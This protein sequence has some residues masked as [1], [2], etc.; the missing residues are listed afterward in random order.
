M[1]ITVQGADAVVADLTGFHSKVNK[2]AV[3]AL[4][5]AL[6]AGRTAMARDIASDTGIGV[7]DVT[8]ALSERKATIDRA[9]AAF[10]A[11]IRRIPLIYFKARQTAT[12]VTAKL[13]GGAGRYPSAFIARMRSGHEGVFRRKYVGSIG[14]RMTKRLPIVELFG[15]SLGHVFAKHRPAA[16]ARTQ[17][18]FHAAFAHELDRLIAKQP[19]STDG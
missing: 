14:T 10:G 8:K 18:A 11:T 3:R 15:P 16:L 13:T 17:E 6:T 4:N 7:R 5:R 12:G 19:E 1:N 2:G 9:E